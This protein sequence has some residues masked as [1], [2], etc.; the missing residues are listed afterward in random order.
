[1]TDTDAEYLA[2]TLDEAKRAL[3]VAEMSNEL[4]SKTE[5]PA[6]GT[7]LEG[8]KRNSEL[9]IGRDELCGV[10]ELESVAGSDEFEDEDAEVMARSIK[11]LEDLR[12]ARDWLPNQDDK[13]ADFEGRTNEEDSDPEDVTWAKTGQLRKSGPPITC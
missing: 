11:D 5:V 8:I 4:A 7:E 1:V 13:D 6:E 9:F 10:L 3:E 2:D 12:G